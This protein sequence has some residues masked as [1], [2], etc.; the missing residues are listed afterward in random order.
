MQLVPDPVDNVLDFQF[1]QETQF[2]VPGA[3][4]TGLPRAFAPALPIDVTGLG[5]TLTHAAL[6]LGRAQAKP[7]VLEKT[8]GHLHRSVGWPAENVGIGDQIRQL[9]T[10]G[11]AYFFIMSQPIAST[12]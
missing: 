12:T 10:H 8:H 11:F 4:F 1:Q 3:A 7:I 9:V 2:T 5:V 6:L